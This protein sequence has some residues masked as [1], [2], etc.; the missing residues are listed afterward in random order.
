MEY[1]FLNDTFTVYE[2]IEAPERVQLDLPLKSFDVSDWAV[3]I[4]D[5][6]IPIAR[7]TTVEQPQGMIIDNTQ[8]HNYT[9]V[10][11]DNVTEEDNIQQQPTNQLMTV[12]SNKKYSVDLNQ[13][14]QRAFDFFIN[15]GLSNNQAAGIV[16]NLMLE[17]SLDPTIVNQNSGA[18]GLA[19]W[20]SSSRKKALFKK[21]GNNPTFDQQLEF[22]WEELNSTERAAFKH[23]L[24]TKT[25]ED[26]VKSFMNR[27]ERPSQKE[28]DESISRRLQYAKELLS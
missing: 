28:K 23:L 21:Y 4:S 26:A 12:K 9:P 16:G 27:F 17:S 1:N 3:G 22:I 25:Y 2:N 19:Q 8:E 6:G 13:R 5:N 18:Y 7:D 24:T 10:V 14:R 15:K 11:I 20:L